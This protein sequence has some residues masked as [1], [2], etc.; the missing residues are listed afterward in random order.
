MPELS[1]NLN[2][3]AWGL[4]CMPGPGVTIH[5]IWGTVYAHKWGSLL[6][7]FSYL[8]IPHLPPSGCCPNCPLFSETAR[9]SF[10]RFSTHLAMVALL[11]ADSCEMGQSL[12]HLP[13]A[14]TPLQFLHTLHLTLRAP[15]RVDHT[16]LSVY[17]WCLSEHWPVGCPQLNQGWGLRPWH[18]QWLQNMPF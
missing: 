12:C 6:W 4:P 10:Q 9:L 11:S 8:E 2:R 16:W 15:W 5:R 13:P 14:L 7:S 17:S 18:F 3:D 1:V